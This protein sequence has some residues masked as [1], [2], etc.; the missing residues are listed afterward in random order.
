M[1]YI[2]PATCK[3]QP[4]CCQ[5]VIDL[6]YYALSCTLSDSLFTITNYRPTSPFK[7]NSRNE[8]PD[9]I[10][11]CLTVSLLYASLAMCSSF[12]DMRVP[13]VASELNKV[14][15]TTKCLKSGDFHLQN[16]VQTHQAPL[17][18]ITN[19]C[20][21]MQVSKNKDCLAYEKF[22]ERKFADFCIHRGGTVLYKSSTNLPHH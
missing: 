11:C 13:F 20:C 16:I 1:N 19:R 5:H 22:H 2:K 3:L 10:M 4:K 17:S 18:S 21:Y 14:M 12:R 7:D 9:V 8:T 6:R 15:C